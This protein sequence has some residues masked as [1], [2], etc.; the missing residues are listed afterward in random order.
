MPKKNLPSASDRNSVG[1]QKVKDYLNRLFEPTV[2]VELFIT[3]GKVRQTLTLEDYYRTVENHF[4]VLI[5]SGIV[6]DQRFLVVES[7]LVDLVQVSNSNMIATLIG[8]PRKAAPYG[9]E[10]PYLK[11]VKH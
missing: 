4:A 7:P 8:Q 5:N 11:E 6:P 9:P 2:E 1:F 3:K 10:A